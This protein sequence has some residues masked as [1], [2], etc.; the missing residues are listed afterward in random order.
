MSTNEQNE[1]KR[2]KK[3]SRKK[4]YIILFSILAVIIG[5]GTAFAVSQRNN[6]AAAR[7]FMNYSTEE[8]MDML[9]DNEQR[10]VEALEDHMPVPVQDLTDE[11]KDLLASNMLSREEAVDILVERAMAEYS[12]RDGRGDDAAQGRENDAD[13]TQEGPQDSGSS[14]DW[15]QATTIQEQENLEAFDLTDDA[16]DRSDEMDLIEFVAVNESV[17]FDSSIVELIAEVYVLRAYF[18]G[19]LDA[20]RGAATSEFMAL[21][22]DQRSQA[23]MMEIGLRYAGTAGNLEAEADGLMADIMSRLSAELQRTGGDT[24]L[25]NEIM[26]SYAEEKSLMKAYFMSILN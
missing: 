13:L 20:L 25:V 4:K 11:E 5:A 1:D 10:I 2:K 23:T 9:T 14:D 26:A 19:Q 7:L 6:I 21:P 17:S 8:L 15:A 24:S 16:I 18:M 22:E 3:K 12:L